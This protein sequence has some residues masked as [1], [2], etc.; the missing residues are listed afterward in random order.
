MTTIY[1]VRHAKPNHTNHNDAER[2]LTEQGLQ[3]RKLV[4]EFLWDKHIDAVL[5]SPYRRCVE[6]VSDFAERAGLPIET[7][8][9]FRERKS[10]DVWERDFETYS[11]RQWS[12]FSYKL[13]GGESLAE[14]QQ[15]NM[16]ALNRVLE[17]YEGKTVAIGTHGAAL[18]TVIHYFDPTFGYED[19]H[20]IRFRMPWIVKFCFDGDRLQEMEKI[21]VIDVVEE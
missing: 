6:T 16:A 20:S 17:K 8:F 18:S 14:V 9:D 19:F 5:S 1:F 11:K 13:P 12:D 2:E 4:T 3:D 21:D 10:S 15:R 7:D